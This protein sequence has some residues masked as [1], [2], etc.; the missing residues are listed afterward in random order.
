MLGAIRPKEGQLHLVNRF[1]V[2]GLNAD[3][4]H[5]YTQR[6]AYVH[7]GDLCVVDVEHVGM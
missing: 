5:S 2:T 6:R 3:L 7:V 1:S 4:S